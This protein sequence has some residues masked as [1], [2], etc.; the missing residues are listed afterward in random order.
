MSCPHSWNVVST[1]VAT[2]QLVL[3]CSFCNVVGTVDDPSLEE[4]ERAFGAPSE[5]YEWDGGDERVVV[6]EICPRECADFELC[7]D[8]PFAAGCPSRG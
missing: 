1:A 2:G 4:W 7:G 8:H 5:P 6:S 3:E